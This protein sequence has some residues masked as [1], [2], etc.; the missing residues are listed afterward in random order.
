MKKELSC[1]A[2]NLTP[3]CERCVHLVAKKSGNSQNKIDTFLQFFQT[4][5]PSYEK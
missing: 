1:F 4:V 2:P 5:N 3:L